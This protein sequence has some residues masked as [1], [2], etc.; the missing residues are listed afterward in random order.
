MHLHLKDDASRM[1][2]IAGRIY[3]RKLKVYA[4]KVMTKVMYDIVRGNEKVKPSAIGIFGLSWI[5]TPRVR[6]RERVVRTWITNKVKVGRRYKIGGHLL[7]N[8]LETG[9][10]I[11]LPLYAKKLFIPL[12]KKARVAYKS[13]RP[14][15]REVKPK[16]ITSKNSNRSIRRQ[17]VSAPAIPKVKKVGRQPIK[18]KYGIDYVLVKKAKATKA[19]NTIKK[20][21]AKNTLSIPRDL[22]R[23]FEISKREAAAS[24][25]SDTRRFF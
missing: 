11:V 5:Q 24:Y 21:L 1:L 13:R 20:A 19:K 4:K 23:L 17:S 16:Q 9:R 14:V 25:R 10:G 22:V 7:S 2:I 18:L 12:T 6:S 15:L 8:L 3:N